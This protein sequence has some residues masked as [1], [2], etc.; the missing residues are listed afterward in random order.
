M[1][2]IYL[3]DDS[4]TM[5]MSIEAIL[6]KAGYQVITNID[7]KAALIEIASKRPDLLITDLNMPIMDG[8]TLIKEVRKIA[9]AKFIPILM[10]TTDSQQSKRQEAKAA[11]ATGWLVKPAKADEMLAVIKR[12]LPGA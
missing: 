6:S 3:V 9:T 10:L 12:V 5:L 11:G 1:K 4:A 2:T 8:I 7:A